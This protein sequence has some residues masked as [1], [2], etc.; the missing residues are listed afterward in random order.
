VRRAAKKK[1]KLYSLKD[2]LKGYTGDNNHREV[3]WGPP[4]GKEE[5]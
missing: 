4:V 3:D 1:R 2:L 5:W